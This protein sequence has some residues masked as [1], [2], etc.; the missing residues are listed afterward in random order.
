MKR[1][2]RLFGLLLIGLGIG[3]TARAQEIR[4]FTEALSRPDSVSSATVKVTPYG[5]AVKALDQYDRSGKP[6]SV[7]GYRIRIFFD[8]G[9]HARREAIETQERFRREF[10]G[11]QTYLGY[12]TPSYMV[13]VGNCVTMDEA[14]MLWNRVRHSFQT[15]FLWRGKIPVSEILRVEEILPEEQPTPADSL[16]VDKM[17]NNTTFNTVQF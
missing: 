14:L 12:E 8:N 4:S 7:P 6:A 15:A 10:P 9:Q 11:I 3:T 17:R 16:Q 5:S 1:M 2:T 13:T